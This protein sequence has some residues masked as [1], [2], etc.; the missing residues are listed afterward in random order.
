MAN[1]QSVLNDSLSVNFVR[2]SSVFCFFFIFSCFSF[3]S[4]TNQIK[5]IRIRALN[6]EPLDDSS[7]DDIAVSEDVVGRHI[8]TT[9]FVPSVFKHSF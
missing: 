8:S 3:I 7:D 5:M 2:S 1:S 4:S 6:E 9:I